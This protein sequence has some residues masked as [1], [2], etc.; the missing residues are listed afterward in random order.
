METETQLFSGHRLTIARQYRGLTMKALAD[1]I[2]VSAQRVTQYEDG[3]S[4]SP[5]SCR[6]MA[7]A[8]GFDAKFFY[9]DEI[10]RVPET[11]TF[12]S[13]RAMTARVRHKTEQA[14]RLAAHMISPE[15]SRRFRLPAV[16]LPDLCGE[17][18]EN[19]AEMVRARWQLGQGPV[20]NVLHVMEANGA[21][22]YWFGEES[23][24]V[25]AV[26][27]WRDGKPFVLLSQRDR[28]GERLRFDAAHEL[29]HLVLHRHVGDEELD[30]R[31]VEAEANRFASA[32][33]LP[34]AQFRLECPL[35]PTLGQFLRLKTRWRV[36]VQAMIRRSRDIGLM[37]QWHYQRLCRELS[38]SWGR[39]NEPNRLV[40]EESALHPQVF[41]M[42]AAKGT[43]AEDIAATTCLPIDVLIALVPA[44]GE[45][46][47]PHEEVS[48]SLRLTIEQLGYDAV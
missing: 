31:Q 23:T 45:H 19:A 9:G 38:A 17:E 26:S 39:I 10:D 15:L 1:L 18:P 3:Q 22:V 30:T 48:P 12:R 25:D 6:L 16:D 33:L 35:F 40:A 21:E 14:G 44:A 4:P 13:R 29:G 27:F 24:C 8:L 41:S 46:R 11:M 7:D 28:G 37:S 5:S 32:F 34:G 47:R 43:Y 42:L 2:G 20:T 36:S